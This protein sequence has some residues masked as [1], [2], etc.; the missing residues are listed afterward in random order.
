MGIKPKYIDKILGLKAK[1]DIKF[2]DPLSE[3]M[4]VEKFK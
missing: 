2:G 4:I 3:E 1:K